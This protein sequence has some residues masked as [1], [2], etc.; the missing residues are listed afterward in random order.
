MLN[1]QSIDHVMVTP[2]T[3]YSNAWPLQL[4]CQLSTPGVTDQSFT[5]S[6]V[7]DEGMM[8]GK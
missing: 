7:L 3:E 8:P 5:S 1:F 2:P 6:V 4:R